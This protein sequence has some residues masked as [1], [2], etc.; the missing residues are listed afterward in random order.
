MVGKIQIILPTLIMSALSVPVLQW[1]ASQHFFKQPSSDT[2]AAPLPV[3]NPTKSFWLNNPG[4]NPL[5][6]EGSDGLLTTDADICIIGS[7]ITGVSTAYHLAQNLNQ[8]DRPTQVVI[9]EAR[10]FCSLSFSPSSF[11]ALTWMITQVLALQVCCP[12]NFQL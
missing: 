10:D 1:Q 8:I 3:P 4:A 9:L 6:K 5:A 7:G 11:S 2:P 12:N